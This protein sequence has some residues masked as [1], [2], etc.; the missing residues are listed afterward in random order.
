MRLVEYISGGRHN[1]AIQTCC[2]SLRQLFSANERSFEHNARHLR[3][4]LQPGPYAS[5]AMAALAR[6]ICSHLR[7]GMKIHCISARSLSRGNGFVDQNARSAKM[8]GK[9]LGSRNPSQRKVLHPTAVVVAKGAPQY[10]TQTH[11]HAKSITRRQ[12][13][14]NKHFMASLSDVLATES[15]GNELIENGVRITQVNADE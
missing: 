15:I 5:T 7:P 1:R 14:L 9:L 13:M 8:L 10:L 2:G 3:R 11:G 4:F 6:E 12:S